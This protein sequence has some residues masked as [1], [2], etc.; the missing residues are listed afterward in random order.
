MGVRWGGSRFLT[1]A[2]LDPIEVPGGSPHMSDQ[3]LSIF[4][5]PEERPTRADDDQE[6]PT[7]VIERP[8]SEKEPAPAPA[9]PLVA[10]SSPR[11]PASG[12]GRAPEFAMVRR[13]GY[14]K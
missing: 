2:R 8:A 3:G 4:D 9:N 14:D 11:T 6:Q 13:G 12:E 7:R 5:E 1:S 10:A